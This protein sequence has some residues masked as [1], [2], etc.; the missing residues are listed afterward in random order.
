VQIY[1]IKHA[2]NERL[3]ALRDKKL[4]IISDVSELVDQLKHVQS[5]LDPQLSKPL[6]S[7]PTMHP[8]ETP[9]K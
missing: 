4:Q 6:P 3:L 8:C 9:E 2:F 1:V 7:V 5:V